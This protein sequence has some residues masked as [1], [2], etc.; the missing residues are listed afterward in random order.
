[1]KR[2]SQPLSAK[3]GE[4]NFRRT[5][6]KQHFSRQLV[7]NK[8]YNQQ[9]MQTAL[10]EKVNRA[11]K[12]FTEL[13]RK[14]FKFSPFLEIGAGYGQ[15]SLL[16]INQFHAS[17]FA[18]DLAHKPLTEIPHTAKILGFSHHVPTLVCDAENLPFADN[19][20]AFIFCYQTLHHFPHPQPVLQEIYRKLRPGGV[21]FF[22]EEPVKQDFNLTL[23]Y[24]PT[25][26]RWW[27]KLK[28]C[29]TG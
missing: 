4:V 27:E 23:W 9:E 10:K 11:E 6:A 20:F 19:S 13:Y 17:G 8:E 24:R 22:S 1:M 16:L 26:L 12:D 14:Q 7:F 5:L 29:F 25:K 15:A 3:I 2:P 18:V 28:S 21:V